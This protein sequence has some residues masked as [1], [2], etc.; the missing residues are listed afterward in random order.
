[1]N[2]KFVRTQQEYRE[3]YMNIW[4]ANS[5]IPENVT[6]YLF[7]LMGAPLTESERWKQINMIVSKLASKG[8]DATNVPKGS[9][10][11]LSGDIVVLS[12]KLVNVSDILL[13]ISSQVK[14]EFSNKV[15]LAYSEY[16]Y[17]FEKAWQNTFREHMKKYG[18]LCSAGNYIPMSEFEKKDPRKPSFH[19]STAMIEGV[20]SLWIDPGHRIM[21]PLDFQ[22][23]VKATEDNSIPVRVLMDWKKAFVVG[24]YEE[25]VGSYDRYPL[26]THWKERGVPVEENHRLIKVK[27][28]GE[29]KA[30]PYPE[31]C[32][33]KEF[34]WGV[35]EYSGRK[36]RPDERIKLA[37][38]VV[39]EIGDITFL[40]YRF[41]FYHE[42]LT[43]SA[44]NFKVRQF[45]SP[46]EFI[47]LL[48]KNGKQYRTNLLKVREELE[49]GA[50]PYTKKVNGKYAVVAPSVAKEYINNAFRLIEQTYTKLNFGTIKQVL[51]VKYVDSERTSEFKEAFNLTLS[52]LIEK[53]QGENII[54]FVILP[55]Q[56]AGRIYYEAKDTF[57]NP[58]SFFDRVKPFQTQCI[59]LENLRAIATGRT[60]ICETLAPQ[61][62]LKLH[63][64]N[65]A[66]W[67]CSQPADAHVY[68]DAGITAYACFDV[69]R[70]REY[71]SEISVFTTV[72]DPYGR[73]ISFDVI[74][75]G[76]EGLTK[77]SFHKLIERIAQVC[78]AYSAVFVKLEPMLKFDLKRIVLY[79]DGHISQAWKN[80]M[81]DAFINGV[82]EAGI[83]PIP[84][85]FKNRKDLPSSLSVDIVGVNKTPNRR[86]YLRVEDNW[87]NVK[88]GTCIIEE[89]DK[90]L[91]IGSSPH[92]DKE[93]NETTTVQPIE[94]EKA[95]HFTINST[96]SEPSVDALAQEY[97]HLTYLNWLSFRQRS[98]FA[99]PQKITQRTGEYISAQVRIP[100]SVIVW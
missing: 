21:I 13:L 96:L 36:Y 81:E 29:T 23:A 24:V 44:L 20:P 61:I 99:L 97:F 27:F 77:A 88:R 70:R 72:T 55:I 53:A 14:A 76:G 6:A 87:H 100:P 43:L 11:S 17:L 83:E 37:Q 15:Q 51:P 32:V 8:F 67:L 98:K 10:K 25:T 5:K 12:T 91:L 16:P 2:S 92:R 50:E 9:K 69:S 19:I 46:K 54:V 35:K 18:F 4:P 33:Y 58:P 47:V 39:A 89:E 66:L 73:F 26:L 40:G 79:R 30:Y 63:G 41:S 60:D 62:Y 95:H 3:I 94:I 1:M 34:E 78:K 38:K 22:E 93:G 49:K 71:K 86:A 65:A 42:P 82:P 59:E 90:C 28:S 7:T 57:F 80:L 52:E 31:I 56:H 75:S 68:N 85:F 84:E 64:K 48:Q 74:H 45:P